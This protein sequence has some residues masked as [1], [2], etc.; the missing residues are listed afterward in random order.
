MAEVRPSYRYIPPQPSQ[1]LT[2]GVPAGLGALIGLLTAQGDYALMP[3]YFVSGALA[4]MLTAKLVRE[5][6]PNRKLRSEEHTV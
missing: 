3:I 2:I 4:F 6:V 5:F 1:F